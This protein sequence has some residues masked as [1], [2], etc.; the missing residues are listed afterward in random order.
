MLQWA[1]EARLVLGLCPLGD[2]R[3][4][5]ARVRGYEP[6]GTGTRHWREQ[7]RESLRSSDRTAT[8][9]KPVRSRSKFSA[10][11]SARSVRLRLEEQ[12]MWLGGNGELENR[13]WRPSLTLV[14]TGVRWLA[15]RVAV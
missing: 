14:A 6:P 15:F 2:A 3:L 5:E 9:S 12:H 13:L 4:L 1:P 8:P 11:K 10:R 7:I